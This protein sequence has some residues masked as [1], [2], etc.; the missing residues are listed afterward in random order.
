MRCGYV[1]WHER[2]LHVNPHL[3]PWLVSRVFTRRYGVFLDFVVSRIVLL[4]GGWCG[5]MDV[6]R[7]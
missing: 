5:E 6:V 1:A 2:H 3:D 7:W 4:C